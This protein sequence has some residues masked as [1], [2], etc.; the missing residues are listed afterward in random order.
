MSQYSVFLKLK[1][2]RDRFFGQQCEQEW[3][4]SCSASWEGLGRFHWNLNKVR[5]DASK[6]KP[7]FGRYPWNERI[8]ENQGFLKVSSMI[9]SLHHWLCN[10]LVNM[11]DRACNVA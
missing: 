6:P 2:L 9:S 1:D 11:E 8:T 10:W 4:K 3:E 5:R 7:K